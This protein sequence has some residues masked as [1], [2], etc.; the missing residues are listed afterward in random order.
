MYKEALL[1]EVKNFQIP[2]RLIAEVASTTD[3]EISRTTVE[4]VING[5]GVVSS[6][7]TFLVVRAMERLVEWLLFLKKSGSVMPSFLDAAAILKALEAFEGKQQR[8][9]S[10]PCSHLLEVYQELRT[11]RALAVQE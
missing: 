7:R 9:P 10:I 1:N 6:L 11:N 3:D 5:S 8:M 4:R 2:T